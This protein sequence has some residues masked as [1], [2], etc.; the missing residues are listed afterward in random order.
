MSVP[1]SIRLENLC[2]H[3]ADTL[4]T[5]F[6]EMAEEIKLPKPVT[7]TAT[8]IKAN[9][10]GTG[11][12]GHAFLLMLNEDPIGYLT[13]S[14]GISSSA[15]RPIFC[16]DDIYVRPAWRSQGIGKHVM[17]KIKELGRKIGCHSLEWKVL[18]GNT[19]AIAFYQALG[20]EISEEYYSCSVSLSTPE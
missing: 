12:V 11:A 5:M 8:N 3:Q 16:I 6:H 4:L 2:E 20:C 9:L 15:A 1:S 18:K 17:H 13:S 19:Q 10:L 14:I 7:A